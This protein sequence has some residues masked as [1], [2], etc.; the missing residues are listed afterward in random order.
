MEYDSAQGGGT[1]SYAA[2]KWIM[3]NTRYIWLNQGCDPL[4]VEIMDSVNKNPDNV[5]SPMIGFV[6]DA[7]D[8]ENELSQ[9]TA[10]I[11]QYNDTIRY[12]M[13]GA[14]F[15]NVYNEFLSKLNAAGID[16][17]VAEGNAQF[18]AK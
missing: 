3:G 16:E 11:K 17:I 2:L 10:V 12:G 13:A 6:F 5:K 1:T 7:T 8:V 15:E 18:N 4:D 14:N 9:V